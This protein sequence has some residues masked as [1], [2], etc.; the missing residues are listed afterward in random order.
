MVICKLGGPLKAIG[1]KASVIRVAGTRQA[2]KIA[3]R[4]PPLRHSAPR[5]AQV[6]GD[7]IVAKVLPRLAFR[8]LPGASNDVIAL[9]AITYTFPLND[10]MD[11]N[12]GYDW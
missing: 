4:R 5:R 11:R 9:F 8:H 2:R 10:I 6:C 7:R 12:V 1:R 3:I